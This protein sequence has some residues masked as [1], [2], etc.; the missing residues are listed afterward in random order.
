MELKNGH[1]YDDYDY[2]CGE[3]YEMDGDNYPL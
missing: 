2:I 1:I 3:E